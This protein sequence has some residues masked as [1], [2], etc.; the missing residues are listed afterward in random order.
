[1]KSRKYSV[2]RSDSHFGVTV[3]ALTGRRMD[4]IKLVKSSPTSRFNTRDG[5]CKLLMPTAR[6]SLSLLGDFCARML[7]YREQTRGT[8]SHFAPHRGHRRLMDEACDVGGAPPALCHGSHACHPDGDKVDGVS[9]RLLFGV[10][11][12]G[13]AARTFCWQT[14]TDAC[15]RVETSVHI[16]LFCRWF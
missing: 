12:A 15:A 9:D 11:D 3:E 16:P 4:K 1:M 6:T 10:G 13:S 2:R 7:S 14:P 5:H 8:P